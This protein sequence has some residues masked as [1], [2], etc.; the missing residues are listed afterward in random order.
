MLKKIQR[1]RI[2]VCIP[3]MN[4]KKLLTRFVKSYVTNCPIKTDF[5]FINSNDNKVC[6]DDEIESL[7]IGS[8]NTFVDEYNG[9]GSVGAARKAGFD[10]ALDIGN[11]LIFSGDDDSRVGKM[12]IEKM[13]APIIQDNRFWKVGHLGGYR[14]FMRDFD[15]MEIRFHAVIGVLWVTRKSV[16]ED[17]GSV[18]VK[19]KVRED[20]EFAARMWHNGGWT[21]IV[22]ADIKHARHQPIES[23]KRTIPENKSEEWN[24]ACNLI[25]S[26][27]PTIFKNKGGK[28]YRQFKWPEHKFKLAD[29]LKLLELEF[30]TN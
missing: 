1:E 9:E 18:D 23:G 27:Y 3:T 13:L 6:V 22:D 21:A 8:G 28:L 20:C 7:I 25:E 11:E 24:D 19:L 5:I 17:I 16:I 4:R 2:T 12:A 26:R 29:D 10:I 15:P 14:A 30:A